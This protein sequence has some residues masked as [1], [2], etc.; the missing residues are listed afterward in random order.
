MLILVLHFLTNIGIYVFRIVERYCVAT[1]GEAA[2]KLCEAFATSHLST[3][4]LK[5]GEVSDLKLLGRHVAKFRDVLTSIV[6]HPD[7]PDEV[8]SR[9]ILQ[10][11]AS[12]MCISLD[13]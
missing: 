1:G 10:R 8:H 5:A 12:V 6:S 13:R 11:G 3:V 2:N 4:G 7:L 9:C